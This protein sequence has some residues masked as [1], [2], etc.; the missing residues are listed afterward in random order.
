M[1]GRNPYSGGPR[2]EHAIRVLWIKR[3]VVVERTDATEVNTLQT[4]LINQIAEVGAVP[5]SHVGGR[6]YRPDNY[7]GHLGLQRCWR[8]ARKDGCQRNKEKTKWRIKHSP[9]MHVS[10]VICPDHS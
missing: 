7:G 1:A 4:A 3:H 2:A 5:S 10:T 9:R 8:K 6:T